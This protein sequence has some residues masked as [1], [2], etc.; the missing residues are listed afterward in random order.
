MLE[1]F[2]HRVSKNQMRGFLWGALCVACS[3][4]W[5]LSGCGV[6]LAI[7]QIAEG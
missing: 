2:G 1:V 7:L 5:T 3:I 6:V 4:D